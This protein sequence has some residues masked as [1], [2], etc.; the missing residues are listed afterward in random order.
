MS[1]PVLKL[2][3]EIE[4]LKYLASNLNVQVQNKKMIIEI[5]EKIYLKIN[6][7]IKTFISTIYEEQLIELIE[8]CILIPE[9]NKK[10][11]EI[12]TY[13]FDLESA[14]NSYYVRALL[15]KAQLEN[16]NLEK[17]NLK[18][19]VLMNELK[20]ILK[21][22]I[23]AIEI[24]SKPENKIKY[25]FLMYNCSITCYNILKK[26]FR[27]Y[28]SKNFCEI[29]E[30]ISNYLEEC[31]DVDFNWRIR[32]LIR[33]I[34]CY[35]DQEKKPNP[36]AT[37]ALDKITDLLKKRSD[38]EFIP[39]LY[40][41]RVHYS[42][43]N[44]GAL[45]NLKKEAESLGNND[46]YGLKFLFTAQAIKS[47][48]YNEGNIEKEIQTFI[49]SI[50]PEFYKALQ[51]VNYRIK[52]DMPKVDAL[53]EC[54]FNL[55]LTFKNS[56]KVNVFL[57]QINEFLS[58]CRNNSMLG[59]LFAENLKALLLLKKQ[60]E[61]S[62]MNSVSLSEY[63]EYM[64]NVR[65]QCLTILERNLI[66]SLKLL[67]LD[68]I[69]DI[70]MLIFNI[71]IPFFKKSLRKHIKKYFYSACDALEQI[72][73]N[74]N[75]LRVSLYYEY[76]KCLIEEDLLQ[77]AKTNLKKAILLDY[78]IPLSKISPLPKPE[79]NVN[80]GYI[81]RD[82]DQYINY[83]LKYVSVKTDLYSDR[84]TPLDI[85]IY[86]ED[87]IKGSKDINLKK[88]KI[89]KCAEIIKN[90]KQEEFKE[91]NFRSESDKNFG[92]IL[93]DEE[94]KEIEYSYK[95]KVLE[96]KKHFVLISKNIMALAVESEEYNYALDIFKAINEDN[97][98]NINWMV[99]Y[100][101]E[102][103][104]SISEMNLLA[105][106]CYENFLLNSEIEIGTQKVINFN[107][108]DKTYQEVEID[109]FNMWKN[110]YLNHISKANM[111]AISCQQYWLVFNTAITLWNSYLPVIRSNNS[112]L[113]VNESVIPILGEIFEGLN[114]GIIYMESIKADI[115]DNEFYDKVEVFINLISFYCKLLDGKGKPE[116]C[117][118]ICE[119][120]LTRKLTSNYRKIF[121]QLKS[122]S[123][124]S[125][126]ISGGKKSTN[127]NT[128]VKDKNK[129]DNIGFTPTL[130]QQ[131]FSD[132]FS[133]LE[134]S[135]LSADEK[136]KLETLKK[137]FE[138][139]KSI[140]INMNEDLSSEIS[141]ELWY[142]YGVQFYE[143]KN[144]FGYKMAIYCS[145]SCVKNYDRIDIQTLK[146]QFMLDKNSN[147]SYNDNPKFRI[148]KWY[149]VGFLLYG[150]CFI[151]LINSEKQERI[152]QIQMCFSAINKYLVS[153]E[154]SELCK[155][156][157]V[158]LQS[159]KAFYNACTLI[160]DQPQSRENLVQHF[161]KIHTIWMN[162][163]VSVLFS[164]PDF[165]L[166]FYSLFCQCIIELKDWELGEF[167]LS[168]A[169]KV[170]HNTKH[171]FLLEY[172]LYFYSKQG[173][174]F[175]QYLNNSDD[176]DPS[177]KAK[178]FIKLARISSDLEEQFSSYNQAI[179]IM[180]NDQNII[181]IDYLQEFASWIYKNSQ[182]FIHLKN[183]KSK[184]V[185]TDSITNPLL[186]VEEQ[187]LQAVD[188]ILEIDS[189][190]DEDNLEDDNITAITKKS[191]GSKLS[192]YS[193]ASKIKSDKS[194]SKNTK[195]KSN[196]TSSKT[197]N[198]NG[199]MQKIQSVFSKQQGLDPYPVYL[200]V[201]H[202]QSLF[203]IHVQLGI[204]NSLKQREYYLDA[205]YFL[206][207][208]IDIS[209][210]TLNIIL[211]FYRN[212]EE[213]DKLKL[214][215][216]NPLE[217]LI[218]YCYTTKEFNVPELYSPPEFIHNYCEWEFP[219]IFLK[220]VEEFNSPN[221]FSVDAF[222][223]QN[224]FTKNLLSI[225][226]AFS[227]DYF[228]HVQ[229]YF[230]LKFA[231]IYFEFIHKSKILKETMIFKLLRLNHNL[232]NTEIINNDSNY[233]SY[234]DYLGPKK[235]KD[236]LEKD[237]EKQDKKIVQTSNK[238]ENKNELIKKY[239]P[240]VKP[241][242]IK[243]ENK[244]ILQER[245]NL[246]KID[247]NLSQSENFLNDENK[248]HEVELV[249]NFPVHCQWLEYAY[250]IFSYGYFSISKEYLE[251]IIFHTRVLKDKLCY[252]KASL[253][254]IKILFSEGNFK[255][256][257]ALIS[258]IQPITVNL[259]NSFSILKI[260][261][262]SL[263][264]LKQYQQ[265][266]SY[267]SNFH[268]SLEELESYN[269][270]NFKVDPNNLKYYK[271]CTLIMKS[272]LS[273][274]NI[275][276][277]KVL[278]NVESEKSIKS[279][280]IKN[281]N[282]S[283][284]IE[285]NRKNEFDNIEAF[286]NSVSGLFE[287][288][289]KI[290]KPYIESYRS[291]KT[292]FKM[293]LINLVLNLVKIISKILLEHP[294]FVYTDEDEI[295]LSIKLIEMLLNLLNDSKNF[296]LQIQSY[297]PIKIEDKP[298]NLPIFRL[299]GLIKVHY[300]EINNYIGEFKDKLKRISLERHK[301][302]S[303]KSSE[304]LNAEI[305]DYLNE[306]TSKIEMNS[307][308]DSNEID[309][310][311]DKTTTN[312]NRYEKSISV[313]I[314]VSILI[315]N[316]IYEF[317]KFTVEKVNSYRL[318]SLHKNEIQHLW[319][320]DTYL[321]VKEFESIQE[322]MQIFI[323]Q[324]DNK[325]KDDQE[326]SIVLPEIDNNL[327]NLKEFHQKALNT[328][329]S[330]IKYR[331][332]NSLFID[333]FD[334][335]INTFEDFNKLYFNLIELTGY[336]NIKS[337]INYL[338]EY[339]NF[340]VKCYLWKVFNQFINNDSREWS[341]INSFNQSKNSFQYDFNISSLSFH[342]N[343][344][345]AKDN[346]SKFNYLQ[347]IFWS[348]KEEE[349]KNLPSNS[350]YFTLQM[351]KDRSLMF[352]GFFYYDSDK[353]Q[354]GSY[355][356]KIPISKEVNLDI[357]NNIHFL[358]KLKNSLIKSSYVTKDDIENIKSEY[359]NHI[360]N[361]IGFLESL[362]SPVWMELDEIIN[363]KI[364]EEIK[365]D[366]KGGVKKEINK[367]DNKN[368][369]NGVVFTDV[370]LPSSGLESLF[371]LIDYRLIDL[372]FESINCFSTIP[373]KSYDLSMCCLMNR[374][375]NNKGS[376]ILNLG[377]EKITY[378]LDDLEYFKK[379]EQI[380]LQE[381]NNSNQNKDKDKKG[382]KKVQFVNNNEKAE[383]KNISGILNT[384]NTNTGKNSE[385]KIEGVPSNI[386]YP[387]IAEYQ[388]LFKSHFI[389]VSQTSLL[390]QFP[391]SEILDN[392]KTSQPNRLGMIFDRLCTLKDF[393]DQKSLIEN[394]FNFSNQPLD[395]I[396]LYTIEG[397]SSLL[398]T[399]WSFDF[400]EVSKILECITI[401]I[402][403]GLPIALLNYNNGGPQINSS[404]KNN[405]LGKDG[406]EIKDDKNNKIKSLSLVSNNDSTEDN[407][408]DIKRIKFNTAGLLLFGLNNVKI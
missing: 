298:F 182:N 9:L 94:K 214:N 40:K 323:N 325:K 101:A 319:S 202:Y 314:S 140:K 138:L 18:A 378:F 41:L 248:N 259:E 156:Y 73:S 406:K 91:D 86:E 201:S 129:K 37:K 25:F 174:S 116:E 22:I 338:F 43:D 365:K 380:N 1:L 136:I 130:E 88:E 324:K 154:I 111:L 103:I 364:V 326:Q 219:D 207:K 238:N 90:Y 368:I 330:L 370:N 118:R 11:E 185:N 217:N 50:Y 59:K 331:N 126:E 279:E 69:H 292:Y 341:Y 150:D 137:G 288:F 114:S 170:I 239:S 261:Y 340:E 381:E 359:N 258:K 262:D 30:K 281:T 360:E 318:Q 80:L 309:Q 146:R 105:C 400:N 358:K 2:N 245:E 251:E 270:S 120:I 290:V 4:N 284:S 285:I 369:G 194:K 64:I 63:V 339:Q 51:D 29:M 246:R 388:Q 121:D 353:N 96:D 221:F 108:I 224:L 68:L 122:K 112:V 191:G 124:K 351:T 229:L 236:K 396:S 141:A 20:I 387:S 215:L 294:T 162:N 361:C 132:C 33:L 223:N 14:K 74:D 299:I 54:G 302:E 234:L 127:T 379:Q 113:I 327:K 306:L 286:S 147:V 133:I 311:I 58:R 89:K 204:V 97:L 85:L 16:V 354:N 72:E 169:L 49:Q 142:K 280:K 276:S 35:L 220:Y 15:I 8:I 208:T 249:V 21:S 61:E 232:L 371:L 243:L 67:N 336:L 398:T 320:K 165:L 334:T 157:F 48:V 28:W 23:N 399:K 407:L 143:L 79:D 266:Y 315:P 235:E 296:L 44:A 167:I 395:L 352:I 186:E 254:L 95:M 269:K 163:K 45:G 155:E 93:V 83:L 363:P 389:F 282:F 39:E 168:G 47:E 253:L 7:D 188:F 198:Y 77:E 110:S 375:K 160:A 226:D 24:I 390:Y 343:I 197:R 230:I 6:Q 382:T 265:A 250:E 205:F 123:I 345:N 46:I 287:C 404:Q 119:V 71:S 244:N 66:G 242:P 57:N 139:L 42:R 256:C 75:Y 316:S 175:I 115:L 385:T 355:L 304:N 374:I 247:I 172:K 190:Y 241:E 53:A 171:H 203:N 237:K 3:S 60:E 233:I 19:E 180:R 362:L 102:Q 295:N 271:N 32:L 391:P 192:R 193:K 231:I 227:N 305:L 82:L 70:C 313:L 312:M 335:S 333:D 26:H 55:Y 36:E 252:I 366:V 218:T 350:S 181:I 228:F 31:Q 184:F 240:V 183:N 263:I 27:Q 158:I 211:F 277:K 135:I 81:Q 255:S 332:L 349:L 164:D 328:A 13:Y 264:Y 179:N 104:I 376:S 144:L 178:L 297:L 159:S 131:S 106:K 225:I 52:L 34:T 322:K 212:K 342:E 392:N 222:T 189:G 176:K 377:N 405:K 38:C 199:A 148:L 401:D 257:F 17:K 267:V 209:F 307:E 402:N 200:N 210:K 78:S 408:S 393:V 348:Y 272:I 206:T 109:K 273:F 356:K 151:K 84:T 268:K 92:K 383:L 347:N 65:N 321:K 300:C 386:R 153:S 98:L 99:K 107:D 145:Q 62:K 187:L 213:V 260:V 177:G 384:L 303:I 293:Y 337:A 344:T 291:N 134:T 10:C 310:Q 397:V 373:L 275:S 278:D 289:E 196:K 329:N 301:K 161:L 283:K 117:L 195:V 173:K 12:L 274:L 403:K 357:D 100:D 87:N 56:S 76:A 216:D 149:A 308:I 152:S 317:C 128:V 394:N 367:K 346:L 5:F 372:P 125:L 166:L